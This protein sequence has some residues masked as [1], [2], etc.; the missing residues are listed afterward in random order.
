MYACVIK[1]HNGVEL[2]SS[3]FARTEEGK[4]EAIEYAERMPGVIKV[5]AAHANEP[6]VWE[7]NPTKKKFK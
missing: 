2:Y 5:E 6:P 1:N 4:E 7:R 3:F